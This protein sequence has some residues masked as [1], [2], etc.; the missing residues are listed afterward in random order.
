VAA[1]VTLNLEIM[2][3]FNERGFLPPPSAHLNLL[4]VSKEEEEEKEKEKEGIFLKWG[5]ETKHSWVVAGVLPEPSKLKT[6]TNLSSVGALYATGP[7]R[8]QWA[9][10]LEWLLIH[11]PPSTFSPTW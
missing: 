8:N 7:Q 3:F 2:D 11:C 4:Q 9:E 6:I 5:G 10:G 1:E